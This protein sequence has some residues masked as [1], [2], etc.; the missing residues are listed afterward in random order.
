MYPVLFHVGPFPVPTHGF[1]TVLGL[2]AGTAVVLMEAR[3]RGMADRAMAT[4]VVGALVGA[5]LG[6]RAGNW[7]LYLT[8]T[9]HPTL[10]ALWSTPAKA[11]SAA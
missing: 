11:C 9:A 2:L 4:I 3:R 8:K 10:P 5:A 7:W 6:A 1:F